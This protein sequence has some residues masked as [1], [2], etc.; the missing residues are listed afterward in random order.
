MK[1]SVATC[2]LAVVGLSSAQSGLWVDVPSSKA[3]AD[4]AVRTDKA[5]RE[6]AKR[7]AALTEANR[8]KLQRAKAYDDRFPFSL[9]TTVRI[10]LSGRALAPVRRAPGPIT[11]VF[12]TTGPRVF[13]AAYRAQL[14]SIFAS[15][16]GTMDVVFGQPASAGPVLVKNFDSDI[17]DRD[18]VAGGYFLPNNGSGQTEIRFPVYT[19][20]EATAVNFVHCLLLAYVGPNAYGFDAFQEG[21]VRAAAMKIVRTAGALPV[22]LDQGQIEAVLGNTYDVGPSYD[23]YNQRALGGKQ[24][25]APN[26]RSVP[27]PAGGSLGGVY[28]LR[29]QMAG[30]AW[31]KLVSEN[32]GFLAE[33]NRR[34]YLAPAAS[35]DIAQ[36]VAIGQAA[37]DTVKGA[38]NSKVEGLSFSDWA[39]RQYILETKDTLGLKL[40]VQPTPITSGLAG[41]DFGVFDVSAT[42]FETQA[43]G[44]EVLLSGTSYP[45]FWDR[46]FDRVFPS[47]QEDQMPIAGAYGSVTPNLPDLY[48]GQPYRCTVDIPVG[49][50]VARAYL[51]AGAIATAAQPIAKNF[52]GTV[53]GIPTG[54]VIR[55]RAVIG[56][57]QVA[58]AL[59]QNGAFGVDVPA[60]SFQGYARMRIDVVQVGATTTTLL[61]R[62]V[63]KGPGEIALDLRIGGEGNYTLP[64]GLLKGIQMIGLP[65]DPFASTGGELLGIPEGDVLLA[66]YNPTRVA[67][68]LYPS[69]GSVNIG[70]GFFLRMNSA[71]TFTIP[72]RAHPGT[73]VS[74]PCKPGW[75]LITCP[76]NE[77]VLTSRVQVIKQ[78]NAPTLYQDAVGVDIGAEFFRFVRGTNDVAS[79]APE[80]GTM[81]AATSFEPGKAYY[82]RVLAPEGVSLVFY[83]STTPQKPGTPFPQTGWKMNASVRIGQATSKVVVGQSNTATRTFDRKEDSPVPPRTGGFQVL[84]D[85]ANPL[86]RDVRRVNTGEKYKLKFE[87]L[88]QG[89]EYTLDLTR[90]FGTAPPFVL[91]DAANGVFKTMQAPTFYRFRASGSTHKIEIWVNGGGQ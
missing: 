38:A 76:L 25:I 39:R 73:A 26:L 52:F 70:N 23:W 12:D 44:N 5:V 71:G 86:H 78:F 62:F 22:G 74:V 67:Y 17:G 64:G 83:P 36:L 13:P 30:S 15:A 47:A 24:F 29:Y 51:P 58:D 68:D 66:R 16:K 54:A 19:S 7:A 61:S 18:A 55:V 85:G 2:F 21:I 69:S 88:T 57:T 33:F 42:Y 89:F 46:A 75:N 50:R 72:A 90:D 4:I 41:P 91:Y 6:F 48:A 56:A 79:G 43:G 45:I 14:E 87:G 9:P 80:T 53:I 11:L 31:Q 1:F 10:A 32:A 28:L 65:V 20:P 3:P 49:D 60:A 35:S 37:L 63:N 27:L 82:V 77:T 40:L 8:A 81:V 34:F 84:V 59:V